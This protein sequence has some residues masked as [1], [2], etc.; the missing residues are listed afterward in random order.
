MSWNNI[1]TRSGTGISALTLDDNE[2]VLRVIPAVTGQRPRLEHHGYYR[3]E[4]RVVTAAG[5]ATALDFTRLPGSDTIRL[6]GTIR[7]GAEPSIQ[8]YAVDDPAHFAA[9]RFKALLEARGVRVDGQPTVRRRAPGEPFQAETAPALAALTPP[10][11]ADD[12]ARINK[13]SQNVHA[14]L[15]LR[16]LGGANGLDGGIEVVAAMMARAGIARTGWDI[17]DGSGM[18]TYNRASPRAMA[19][20]LR[21]IERQPWGNAWQ[22]SLP[23]AG[24]DGT[25]TNRFRGTPLERRLFAK[26][27]SINATNALSGYLIARSGRRLTFAFFANDV[28]AGAGTNPIMDAA[29]IEIAAAN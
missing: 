13:N 4:N 2:V 7:T 24:V 28:P 16:R 15:L 26:T 21:W 5:A 11:L 22:G 14:E 27:G 1:H 6:T 3:V 9:W 17:S 29:L 18:S 25:L 10:P 8:R 19:G 23:I 12:I 20:L